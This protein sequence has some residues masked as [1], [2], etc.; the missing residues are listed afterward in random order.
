MAKNKRDDTIA[1]RIRQDKE[2]VLEQLRTTPIVQMAVKNAGVGR[3]TYYTWRKADARFAK[4]TD[5]AI[6]E[7]VLM[8]NDIAEVQLLSLVK[9][10][11]FEAIRFWLTHRH[12]SYANKLELKGNLIHEQKAL[13]PAQKK[14]VRQALKLAQF[15]THDKR[16]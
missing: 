2:K 11:K 15:K 6:E 5:Q 7:G 4:A 16:Q 13:T 10:K 3:T 1:V 9:E 12:P 14:L 8:M